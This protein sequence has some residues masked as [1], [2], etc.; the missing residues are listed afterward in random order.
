MVPPKI[1]ERR[2]NKSVTEESEHGSR[3]VMSSEEHFSCRKKKLITF[4]FSAAVD[5]PLC[6]NYISLTCH[7][8]PVNA[9]QVNDVTLMRENIILD[10][11]NINN[12]SKRFLD[13][14]PPTG[15][16]QPFGQSS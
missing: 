16:I 9:V 2:C 8:L 10:P 5:V 3:N 1:V 15:D 12:N 7:T 11:C 6:N 14:I 13:W 4:T